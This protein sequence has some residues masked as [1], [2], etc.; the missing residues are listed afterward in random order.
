MLTEADLV[1]GGECGAWAL[2]QET[3]RLRP[4]ETQKVVRVSGQA[5]GSCGKVNVALPRGLME[6]GAVSVGRDRSQEALA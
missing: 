6:E 4:W 3:G 2:D 1:D 5:G